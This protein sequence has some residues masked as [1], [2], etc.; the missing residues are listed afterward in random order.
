MAVAKIQYLL[1]SPDA[2][3]CANR[4]AKLPN[5]GNRHEVI[6]GVLYM[7]TSPSFSISGSS[8]ASTIW[9]GCHCF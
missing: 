5:D 9:L 6:D 8:T 2:D 4:W 7:S 3:W 1:R